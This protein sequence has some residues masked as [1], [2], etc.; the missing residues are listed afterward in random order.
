MNQ[1]VKHFLRALLNAD[2]FQTGATTEAE[3][4]ALSVLRVRHLLFTWYKDEDRQAGNEPVTRLSDLTPKML[5]T[6]TAPRCKTKAAETYGLLRFS[7]HLA[8]S[9]PGCIPQFDRWVQAGESLVRYLR[10]CKDSPR[11][12]NG[13]A[14]QVDG[15]V[16]EHGSYFCSQE[17]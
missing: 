17:A 3:K 10:L 14:L 12:F 13:E 4:V 15:L 1:F 5:G 2:A 7:L 9:M 8:R 11:I 6:R 16:I